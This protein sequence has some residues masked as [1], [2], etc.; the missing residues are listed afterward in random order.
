MVSKLVTDWEARGHR[1]MVDGLRVFV[2]DLPAIGPEKG[3]PLLVLHGFPTSSFDWRSVIEPVRAAGRRVVL[4]DF[5]GFGLS[6]KPDV[7][8]SIRGYAD[9]AEAVA[10]AAGLERVVLA[11][12]DLGDSVGGEILARALE[13]SLQFEV[14]NR[15]ISNGSIYMDL[16]QLT[17]GQ[18]M[19]LAAEDA[20]FDLAA[21]GIDPSV[22]FKSGVAGTF[23]R[24]DDADEEDMT[25]HWELASYQ[26][27]HQLLART[28]R[29]IEDR[30]LEERRFTGA[31]EEH[32]S[33][34]HIIWGRLDPVA[35]Y[36]MARRLHEI[37]AEAPL[38]T[39]EDIGHYPMVEAPERFS[40]AMLAA[41]EH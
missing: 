19:L 14:T 40:T 6:D 4:F 9:T 7:R 12:H 34:L 25:A 22:G 11:T 27:G 41:L 39:L 33:P 35:V 10:E 37:R 15:I 1:L 8:Y 16:V 17:D 36:P 26:D 23:A 24:P 38:V 2:L 5:L 21:L 32:P 31:I 3:D 18:Q 13:G 29:Y 28:I 30:R 20:R